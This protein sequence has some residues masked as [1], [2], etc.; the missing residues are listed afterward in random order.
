MKIDV[1]RGKDL[2]ERDIFRRF[3]RAA[4]LHVE[5]RSVRSSKPP[6]PDI[7]C[8][9]DDIPYYFE[10]TRMVHPGSAELMGRHL[11]QLG[12]TG[13]APSLGFD[14]YDD[15]AALRETIERKASK[16]YQT[17]GRPVMLLIYID[18]ALHP[19][20]MLPALASTILEE[21]GPKRHWAGIWLYDD[22]VMDV[23]A[24]WVRE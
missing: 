4:G 7:S 9:L 20:R 16:T 13:S 14:T 5:P 12:R 2:H 23:I 21:Q 15:R 8:R 11:S 1:K 10:L 3:V 22:A 18:G 19:P 6:N 17:H 24:R